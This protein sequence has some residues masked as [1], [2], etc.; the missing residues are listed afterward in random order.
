MTQYATP[1]ELATWL[2]PDATDPQPPANA[3]LLLREATATIENVTGGS[4]YNVDRATGLPS[5]A[6]VALAMKE[7]VLQQAADLSTNGIDPQKADGG[8]KPEVASKSLAG[9]SVSYIQNGNAAATRA[10]LAGGQVSPRAW[11]YLERAGL[12]TSAVQTIPRLTDTY[13]SERPI[14]PE[15][16]RL[17]YG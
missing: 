16:G 15:T 4:V 10:A 2:N 8:L 12:L 1:E 11:A 6:H 14:D 17:I 3:N 13:L 9:M 7:A 5:D